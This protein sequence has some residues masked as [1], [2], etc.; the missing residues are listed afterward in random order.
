MTCI[1]FNLSSR[2]EYL[3]SYFDNS[4]YTHQ[5][6]NFIGHANSV[7][8]GSSPR[9]YSQELV[10]GCRLNILFHLIA[11]FIVLLDIFISIGCATSA[12]DGSSPRGYEKCLHLII[13][14]RHFYIVILEVFYFSKVAPERL[15]KNLYLI[16]GSKSIQ[17][18]YPVAVLFLFFLSTY[19]PLSNSLHLYQ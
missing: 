14:S 5:C 1:A 2:W 10:L 12:P 8:D 19:S 4:K 16:K 7:P 17:M 13:G 9:G 15:G 11:I 3:K 6:V 18:I